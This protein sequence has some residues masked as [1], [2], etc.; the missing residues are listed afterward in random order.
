MTVAD[1][2]HEGRFLKRLEQHR[3][4]AAGKPNR[5][6]LIQPLTGSFEIFQLHDKNFRAQFAEH[7]YRGRATVFATGC[8][9][10]HGDARGFASGEFYKKL[11]HGQRRAAAT[12][13]DQWPRLGSAH[14]TA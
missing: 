6:C 4:A 12:H 13:D 10:Q 11:A 2:F 7:F 8:L 1:G 3:L 5:R 14:C 9:R